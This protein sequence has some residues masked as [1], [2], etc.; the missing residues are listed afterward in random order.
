MPTA[1]LVGI[2][3]VHVEL[4]RKLIQKPRFQTA[5]HSGLVRVAVV[6]KEGDRGPPHL[7]KQIRSIL[8]LESVHA[9]R[10]SV[11]HGERVG[12]HDLAQLR[13]AHALL[14]EA[15]ILKF[16][17]EEPIHRERQKAQK[18]HTFFFSSSD[19]IEHSMIARKFALKRPVVVKTSAMST[20]APPTLA[21]ET[22]EASDQDQASTGRLHW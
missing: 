16:A 21:R 11:V 18:H 1:Q 4:V 17:A 8:H 9:L 7:E 22:H 2:I 15:L 3:D 6:L 12:W 20:T 5:V 13:V 10:K 14:S 19:R